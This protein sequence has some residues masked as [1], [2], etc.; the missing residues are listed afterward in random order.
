MCLSGNRADLVERYRCF[1][2][3]QNKIQHDKPLGQKGQDEA[4]KFLAMSG[5]QGK[6]EE[7]SPSVAN[8][9]LDTEADA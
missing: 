9:D 1:V 4:M 6:V 3:T 2:W 8:T 5:A 7:S